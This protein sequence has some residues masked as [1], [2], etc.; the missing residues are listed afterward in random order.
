MV[1]EPATNLQIQVYKQRT[2]R[3]PIP[4]QHAAKEDKLEFGLMIPFQFWDI[5]GL[6]LRLWRIVLQAD[7]SHVLF[8]AVE[9]NAKIEFG[10]S[11]LVFCPWYLLIFT[12]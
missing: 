11:S 12:S 8:L 5:S 7:L 4:N 10:M 1:I 2:H 9:R 3:F 6:Y